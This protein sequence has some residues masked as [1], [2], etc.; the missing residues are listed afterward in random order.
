MLHSD[1]ELKVHFG[2]ILQQYY[3]ALYIS[4]RGAA[5]AILALIP[6]LSGRKCNEFRI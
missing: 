6:K 1:A 2:R 4:L 3:S 5:T